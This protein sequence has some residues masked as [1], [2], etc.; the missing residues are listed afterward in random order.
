MKLTSRGRY[1]TTAMLDLALYSRERAVSLSDIS[2][3]QGISLPYLGQLFS[4]LRK[5]G[6][7]ISIRGPGGGYKLGAD[8]F[9]ISIGTIITAVD[10]SVDITKCNGKTDCRAGAPCLTHALWKE[11]GSRI[12]ELLH[13]ITLGELMNNTQLL[14]I[15]NIFK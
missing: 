13:T 2:E 3:R 15:S 4:K 7:V 10:G 8:S 1:A 9:E 12:S 11:L 14:E 6:L 5:S